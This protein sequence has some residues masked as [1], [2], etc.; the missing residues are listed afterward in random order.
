MLAEEEN[1]GLAQH[2]KH[3]A[4]VVRVQLNVLPEHRQQLLAQLSRKLKHPHGGQK[5]LHL[6]RRLR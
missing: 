2:E 6:L 5:Q 4:V 1:A 3:R